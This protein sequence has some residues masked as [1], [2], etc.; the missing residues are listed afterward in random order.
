MTPL[1]T[2]TAGGTQVEAGLE[3]PPP[4]RIAVGRGTAFVLGGYCYDRAGRTRE[5]AVGIGGTR[6]RVE[7]LRLPRDDVYGRLDPGD[8][9]TAHAYRSGFVSLVDLAPVAT[10]ARLEVELIVTLG[11]GGEASVPAG[12]I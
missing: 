5:L 4:A 9:A 11:N 3:I 7:R 10:A 12:S 8:P 6:Q 1:G 2:S